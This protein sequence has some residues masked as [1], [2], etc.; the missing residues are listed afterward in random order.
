MHL[1][2]DHLETEPDGE[3]AGR[4]RRYHCRRHA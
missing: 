1:L 2:D 4:P 3:A